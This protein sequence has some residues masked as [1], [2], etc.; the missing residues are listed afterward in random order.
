MNYMDMKWMSLGNRMGQYV[1][2]KWP[3]EPSHQDLFNDMFWT[4]HNWISS[5]MSKLY[6]DD[7]W[8][9]VQEMVTL[10]LEQSNIT[11]EKT[12]E[13]LEYMKYINGEKLYKDKKRC[14]Y[15]NLAIDVTIDIINSITIR[16]IH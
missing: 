1:S 3:I 13:N 15:M 8:I 6:T 10:V 14:Y 16:F 2:T 11:L 12:I 4:Q 5:N 7:Y 9:S